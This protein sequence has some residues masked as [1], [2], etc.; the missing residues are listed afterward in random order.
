MS[1]DTHAPGNSSRE[2]EAEQATEICNYVMAGESMPL[3][4]QCDGAV[5]MWEILLLQ[6]LVTVLENL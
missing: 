3:T 1:V 6:S 4:R 2:P 5:L